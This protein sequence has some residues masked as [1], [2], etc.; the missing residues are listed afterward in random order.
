MEAVK[1][2]I[3]GAITLMSLDD[4]MSLWEYIVD[5]HT[6]RTSLSEVPEAEPT[7]E[8][9]RVIKA[10]ENGEEEYQPYISHEE[11]KRQLNL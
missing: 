5:T 7:E 1:E 9:M 10:Y 4:A 8:E 3:I 2:R 6:P 11:L